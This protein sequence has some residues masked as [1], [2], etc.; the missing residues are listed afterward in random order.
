MSRLT[1]L[2]K[3]QTGKRIS[4]ASATRFPQVV[5]MAVGRKYF[6]KYPVLPW[7]PFNAIKQLNSIIQLD[8]KVLE[9]GGGMSTVWL[10][11]R[12]AFVH[13]IE[14]SK[15]WFEMLKPQLGP[16]VKLE[17]KWVRHEMCDFTMYPDEYFDLIFID[18][19]PRELCLEKGYSKVRN[20]GFIYVDN[21]D[22]RS[23]TADCREQLESFRKKGD[24]L[25]YFADFVPG[26][27]MVNEGAILQKF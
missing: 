16:N 13:S 5:T 25:E 20:Q 23:L 17:H 9:I 2:Y 19:G 3:S 7:I 8:F 24:K 4:L 11:K 6:Q 18:G 10:S 27:V 26:N 14:A 15:E 12:A 21:I 22:D 1:R